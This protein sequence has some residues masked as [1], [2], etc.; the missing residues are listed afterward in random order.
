MVHIISDIWKSEHTLAESQLNGKFL[1][2]NLI[3]CNL[4]TR[5]SC[6]LCIG[7]WSFCHFGLN[8]GRLFSETWSVNEP[9]IKVSNLGK[10]TG[11]GQKILTIPTKPQKI[12]YLLTA[13]E[14]PDL[15]ANKQSKK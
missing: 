11:C 3:N 7:S 5:L 15:I 10:Y 2:L 6:S 12:N 4:S 1:P 8:L 13:T 14:K 9:S